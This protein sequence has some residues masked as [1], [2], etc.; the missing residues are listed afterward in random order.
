LV[1]WK[2]T[3]EYSTAR[4]PNPGYN[5]TRIG[6]YGA[7]YA[8]SDGPIRS[9][10]IDI[11]W[12]LD[13]PFY[14]LMRQQLLAWRLEQDGAEGAE[15]V[16]VLHVLPPQN[17]AYQESLVR[18]QH[19]E[20]G[21][22]VTEVWATLLRTPDRFTHVDPAVFLDES[23]TS[24][25]YVDRYSPT[26]TGSLPWGVSVWRDD[27]RIVAAAYVYDNG[28]EWCHRRPIL[29]PPADRAALAARPD[30]EYFNL[31]DDE[32]TM[33]VGTLEYARAFLRAVVAT[34]LNGPDELTCYS[35]P[36]RVVQV[37]STWPPLDLEY[38]AEL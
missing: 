7:D 19:K 25:D 3:E 24:W 23:V 27:N 9:E 1:E 5:T 38:R 13:E 4:K 14:Q 15:V 31:A 10:L 33:I 29:D 18:P 20:L 35:W 6:R 26:G 2:Y 21:S 8:N 37:I 34:D 16:R 30:R 11:E 22:S 12:M 28:F 32:K 17:R 36:D